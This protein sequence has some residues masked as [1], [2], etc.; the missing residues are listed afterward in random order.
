M[1]CVRA[2]YR[3]GERGT[4]SIKGRRGRCALEAPGE[5]EE[6]RPK[7]EILHYTVGHCCIGLSGTRG[8][9]YVGA[10]GKGGANEAEPFYSKASD[11]GGCVLAH[12]SVAWFPSSD[13]R[14]QVVSVL[15]VVRCRLGRR[16]SVIV[17]GA[18]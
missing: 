12:R 2:C 17:E 14:T 3:R 16:R 15:C 4:C 9:S 8:E 6:C 11:W 1:P 7:K 18:P 5:A 10:S 13:L